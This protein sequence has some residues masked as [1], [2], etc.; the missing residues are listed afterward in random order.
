[1]SLLLREVVP[2]TSINDAA[3]IPSFT[4]EAEQDVLA[5]A[6]GNKLLICPI[7][8]IETEPPKVYEFNCEIKAIC[9]ISYL[10]LSNILIIFAS[11]KACIFGSDGKSKQEISL[12]NS[13]EL[14]DPMEIKYAIHPRVFA[15]QTSNHHID[16]YKIK[17]NSLLE[18]TTTCSLGCKKIIDFCFVGPTERII[19]LAVLA[20]NFSSAPMIHTIDIKD[21]MINLTLDS[22]KRVT[23]PSDAYMIFPIF[24]NE[25]SKIAVLTSNQ[26]KRVSY[27]K[28]E[29]KVTNATI[30]TLDKILNCDHIQNDLFSFVDEA[31]SFG[32]VQISNKGNVHFEGL[33]STEKPFK[34]VSLTNNLLFLASKVAPSRFVKIKKDSTIKVLKLFENT[35]AV[36]KVFR[37][38]Y[39][40]I[41]LCN[42]GAIDVLPY[43]NIEVK[44]RIDFIGGIKILEYNNKSSSNDS[45]SF[46]VSRV[47][48]AI[49][50]H[51]TKLDA[52]RFTCISNRKILF[53]NDRIKCT[54]SEIEIDGKTFMS[55]QD[56]QKIIICSASEQYACIITESTTNNILSQNLK[57]IPLN[58]Q[59]IISTDFDNFFQKMNIKE[60]IIDIL[61]NNN[62]LVI[63][64]SYAVVYRIS[65]GEV[66][67]IID[68]PKTASICFIENGLITLDTI[69]YLRIYDFNKL[70]PMVIYC[71][72]LHTKICPG[73]GYF[74]ICGS[75]PSLLFDKSFSV[76][77]IQCEPFYDA[78]YLENYNQKNYIATLDF[79]SIKIIKLL[80][81]S[82]LNKCSVFADPLTSFVRLPNN[83]QYSKQLYVYSRTRNE[84][85]YFFLN[86]G[87]N[88]DLLSNA[89][90]FY[91]CKNF[92]ACN[93]VNNM[94]N[95]VSKNEVV[96][97]DKNLKPIHSINIE[98]EILNFIVNH[99]KG[100][101]YLKDSILGIDSN[102]LIFKANE[103]QEISYVSMND[104][105]TLVLI[106]KNEM[107]L[108]SI[109]D[110]YSYKLADMANIYDEIT[111]ISLNKDVILVGTKS[112][113]LLI[114]QIVNMSTIKQV[115]SL[116]FLTLYPSSIDKFN[117]SFYIGFN[118]GKILEIRI[119]D[120]DFKTEKLLKF[121]QL[122]IK[123]E[124]GF[125]VYNQILSDHSKYNNESGYVFDISVFEK[126]ASLPID[127]QKYILR[128]SGIAY[129]EATDVV[130]KYCNL[131]LS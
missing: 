1:M 56:N 39:Q 112:C 75:N 15:F 125:T 28:T 41:A 63:V 50:I 72:G 93:V 40:Y 18:Y 16:I 2:A 94:I 106:N 8:T 11:Y 32:L 102:S 107:V 21:D 49:E 31:G 81:K 99:S 74:I 57:I 45:Y 92:V 97:F 76:V 7:S 59:C 60:Q 103:S 14:L 35:G 101:I 91:E 100:Y 19:R 47:N 23:M 52:N 3:L 122:K 121:L 71:P 30:C 120:A 26:L 62:F 131:F 89:H 64:T 54:E 114:F 96:I 117:N 36:T 85:T 111:C 44:E 42:R 66:I 123:C 80:G 88:L 84:T 22:Q 25:N 110:D 43:E 77:P 37:N 48:E 12:M 10:Q 113:K 86:S 46:V 83:S 124:A 51:E 105:Y 69:D 20:S 79:N 55:C 126:Y 65:N 27:R 82:F 128:E 109:N 5:I 130:M 29:P 68:T 34:V 33:G 87:Q 119:F 61:I 4:E 118:N 104:R 17:E 129:E 95:I 73:N 9:P 115:N 116:N 58:E 24:P 78:I 38:N 98:S 127:E 90:P 53:I 6:K 70:N 108:F 13:S 67:K